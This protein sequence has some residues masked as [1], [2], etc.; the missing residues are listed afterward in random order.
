[1]VPKSVT[2]ER[3]IGKFCCRHDLPV[4]PSWDLRDRLSA[5]LKV[6]DF[7]EEE[8]AELKAI[9]KTNHFRACHPSW[10][11]WGNLGFTD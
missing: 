6:V 4:R 8:M 1:V 9:D 5:N 11:G 7:T 3:I 2:P 10:T